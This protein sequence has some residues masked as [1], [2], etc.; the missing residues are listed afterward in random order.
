VLVDLGFAHWLGDAT[1]LEADG[2]IMGTA[3]YLA[4]ERGARPPAVDFA[5]DWFSF[6]VTLFEML[7][8]ILPHAPRGMAAILNNSIPEQTVPK[9]ARPGAGRLSALLNGLLA[10]TPSARPRGPLVVHE[11]IALEIAALGHRRAG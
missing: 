10:P 4:P 8:G 9:L 6:G 1:S 7:T 2:Y 11:L 5:S 3:N